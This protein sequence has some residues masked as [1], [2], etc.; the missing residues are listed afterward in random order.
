MWFDVFMSRNEFLWCE[1]LFLGRLLYLALPAM[2]CAVF[3]LASFIAYSCCSCDDGQQHE[4][5]LGA[6]GAIMRSA[7]IAVVPNTTYFDTVGKVLREMALLPPPR[8]MPSHLMDPI[9]SLG[10]LSCQ[11]DFTTI[12]PDNFVVLGQS[13]RCVAGS[14]YAG[15]CVGT[16]Y[17]FAEFSYKAKSLWSDQCLTSWPC[18]RCHRDYRAP[19]PDGWVANVSSAVVCS[20]PPS[21]TGCV[22]CVLV[23]LFIACAW[24]CSGGPCAGD[25]FFTLHNVEMLRSWSAECGAFWPCLEEP[26]P[27]LN[28]Y[29]LPISEL[30]TVSRIQRGLQ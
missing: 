15:P 21:Y 29:I 22:I 25:H 26:P 16:A 30:A 14:R 13:A 3:T 28:Q 6:I 19:C 5:P 7:S 8:T 23:R 4:P 20:P 12:C 24:L 11:R 18:V 10:T 2:K 27:D 17:S 1:T 9:S